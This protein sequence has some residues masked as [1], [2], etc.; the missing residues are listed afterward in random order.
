MGAW[1]PFSGLEIA[2]GNVPNHTHIR[3]FASLPDLDS[4]DGFLDV[5][6]QPS[7][8]PLLYDAFGVATID[9]ISSSSA[10]D[11]VNIL[12]TGLDIAGHVRV[13][14]AVLDGQNKVTLTYPLYRCYRALNANGTDLAGDI[15]IYPDTPIVTGIPTDKTVIRAYIDQTQQQTQMA[16]YTIPV[17]SVG[18]NDWLFFGFSKK[19]STN[20]I[21][22]IQARVLNG[23]WLDQGFLTLN[24]T[25][26]S[27]LEARL[28]VPSV[29]SPLTDI[30]FMADASANDTA[31]TINYIVILEEKFPNPNAD[32]NRA[33]TG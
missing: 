12:I 7:K 14:I 21:V 23:V 1:N 13:Q 11:T 17:N 18:Y 16:Q 30:R 27:A 6:N 32:E 20:S 31:L 15:Y 9:T 33:L 10:A 24:T 4:G 29:I 26:T 8:D 22:K 3:K 25:G 2:K 28:S 19:T 5:W